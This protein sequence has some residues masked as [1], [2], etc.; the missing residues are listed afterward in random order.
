M[1]FNFLLPK[2]DRLRKFPIQPT[3]NQYTAPFFIYLRA[4]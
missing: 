2:Q 1:S 4:K 3:E